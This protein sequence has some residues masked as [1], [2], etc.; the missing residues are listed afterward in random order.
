MGYYFKNTRKN[1]TLS[2]QEV[3]GTLSYIYKNKINEKNE[4]RDSD[5]IYAKKGKEYVL[6]HRYSNKTK[7]RQTAGLIH[8]DS[9]GERVAASRGNFCF[10]S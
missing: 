7:I 9:K 3:F 10:F 4:K 8:R 6:Q 2:K 5:Q 1:K